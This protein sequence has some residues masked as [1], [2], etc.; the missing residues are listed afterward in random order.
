[1]SDP[2]LLLGVEI[3]PCPFCGATDPMLDDIDGD[4]WAVC[5]E[6]CGAIGPNVEDDLSDKVGS[7]AIEAWNKRPGEGL[8]AGIIEALNSGD[9]VYRP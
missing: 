7:A 6:D 5:C 9:G 3:K 1:M 2:L 4:V 8:P